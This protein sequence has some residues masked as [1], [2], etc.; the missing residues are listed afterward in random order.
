[1]GISYG[2]AVS[3]RQDFNKAAQ[4][5]KMALQDDAQAHAQEQAKL[6]GG[7][8]GANQAAS[9]GLQTDGQLKNTALLGQNQLQ[10]TRLR[11]Q[12]TS[13]VARL[14]NNLTAVGGSSTDPW[15]TK[16]GF[17]GGGWLQDLKEGAKAVLGGGRATPSPQPS[18]P[19]PQQ[20]FEQEGKVK[21]V[22]AARKKEMESAAKGYANSGVIPGKVNTQVADD[23]NINAKIGEYIIPQE[24]VEILG[25]KKLDK[26][27][28][29]ARK[30]IGVPHKTG[31][32]SH[33]EPDAMGRMDDP[34]LGEGT[35]YGNG[36]E[37]ARRQAV[38]Y[39][40][41]QTMEIGNV[42][43][44]VQELA[45]WSVADENQNQ[46]QNFI[47]AITSRL[48]RLV[49]LTQDPERPPAQPVQ[50][51]S[52]P[53]ALQQP[54]TPDQQTA[55]PQ[56][57]DMEAYA[58]Q[59]TKNAAGKHGEQYLGGDGK[60]K[61]YAPNISDTPEQVD[62][63]AKG[64]LVKDANG[65]W[66]QP[67]LGGVTNGVDMA[68]AQLLE[69]VA[70]GRQIKDREMA[71]KEKTHADDVAIKTAAASRK[72][73]SKEDEARNKS[74]QSTYDDVVKSYD[75]KGFT[76]EAKH[77]YASIVAKAN[78]AEYQS[79][80]DPSGTYGDVFVHPKMAAAFS[81]QLAKA[82]T[83]EQFLMVLGSI[84]NYGKGLTMRTRVK[85]AKGLKTM[86]SS[87]NAS[88]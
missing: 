53:S 56:R 15:K 5:D 14:G 19:P 39:S 16:L 17:S 28:K 66:V 51:N 69:R 12:G 24:V 23:I 75:W 10:D 60:W 30:Q 48:G 7:I 83:A 9:I 41:S 6:E 65:N 73:T 31:P 25:A 76:P 54:V 4:A 79:I 50:Q 59:A 40:D 45:P 78:D 42:Q 21:D 72:D 86:K 35:G 63:K 55:A 52:A 87:D 58:K 49:G 20:T 68:N 32:K 47:P 37:V 38:P 88:T 57:S 71:L 26:M 13:D 81:G 29:D 18:T 67:Q 22:I 77:E 43:P 46:R 2:Q 3:T 34:R 1:M 36:T 64:Q 70:H 33:N 85:S 84:D 80:Q 82:K 8:Q 74:I 62:A 27:V 11:N 44:K 61:T